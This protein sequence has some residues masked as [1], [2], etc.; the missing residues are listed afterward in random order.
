MENN[1]ELCV[2]DRGGAC[3]A[4]MRKECAGC[5]FESTEGAQMDSMEA[6]YER[7]RMLPDTH[8]RYMAS[9]YYKG[10]RPWGQMRPPP[11]ADEGRM[12][13]Q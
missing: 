2:F 10:R 4:L 8:Q 9:K 5:A 13:A 3:S 1:R 11:V 12:T 7:L 6:A